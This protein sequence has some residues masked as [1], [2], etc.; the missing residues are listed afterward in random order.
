MECLETCPRSPKGKRNEGMWFQR[1]EKILS[2][3]KKHRD[4]HTKIKG[5]LIKVHGDL[6]DARAT[7]TP[8]T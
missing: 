5:D 6:D 8:A 2:E 3:L 7:M 4:W 1:D